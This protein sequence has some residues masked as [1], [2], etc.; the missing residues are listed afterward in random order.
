MRK[1]ILLLCVLLCDETVLPAPLRKAQ[2]NLILIDY[3]NSKVAALS[4]K[5]SESYVIVFSEERSSMY[6]C[7]L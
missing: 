2:N 5:Y 6:D 1:L 4:S 7:R 3:I